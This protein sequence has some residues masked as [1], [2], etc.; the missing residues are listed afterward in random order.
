MAFEFL[1]YTKGGLNFGSSIIRFHPKLEKVQKLKSLNRKR[2]LLN[3][4]IDQ[5]YSKNRKELLL[6]KRNLQELWLRNDNDFFKIVDKIFSKAGWP[7]GKYI[8][9]IS[10]FPSGPRFLES[11]T[12]QSFYKIGDQNLKQMQH[13]MLH[14]IFYD[15]LEKKLTKEFIKNN[16]EKVWIL[17]EV[18]NIIVLKQKPY[19]A[20]E[21]LIPFYQTLWNSSKNIDEF[22]KKSL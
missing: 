14:F 2:R 12:F 22:L 5:F 3:Q 21:K 7:K 10:I 17:S 15:Y 1:N 8:C 19:P 9:Y 4:Y 13:E 16:Q 18:F 11:K 20:H 6:A